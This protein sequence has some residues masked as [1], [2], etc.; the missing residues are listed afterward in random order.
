M[1]YKIIKRL[2]PS[3]DARTFGSMKARTVVVHNTAMDAS[4][5]NEAQ[6][7]HSKKGGVTYHWAVDDKEAIQ[8][9]PHNKSGYHAG[10]GGKKDGGRYGIGVEICYSKSGGARYNKAEENA[11]HLCAQILKEEGLTINNLSKHQ[12]WSGKYCPHRI[13]SHTGW[14]NFKNKVA[15]YMK[16]STPVKSEPLKQETGAMTQDQYILLDKRSVV[17]MEATIAWIKSKVKSPKL[18]CSVDE[19]VKFYYI[20]GER[21]NV[22]PDIALCLSIKETGWWQYGGI[23]LPNQNNF[24]GL[25]AFNNNKQGDAASFKNAQIGAR[26]IVQHLRGYATKEKPTQAI[27]DPRYQALI[28]KKLLGNADTY[29]KLSGKWAW[30]GYNTKK[31]KSY[32]DAY[33]AGETYGQDI[34]RLYEQLKKFAETYKPPAEEE[35]KPAPTPKPIEDKVLIGV[36]ADASADLGAAFRILNHVP[37]TVLI[38]SRTSLKDFKEVIQVGGSKKDGTTILLSGENRYLTDEKVTQWLEKQ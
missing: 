10:D 7:V 14:Q 8:L 35:S 20:E 1:N 15:N 3:S 30:P 18:T 32:N 36:L 19:L 28:D 22:R 16:Q 29:H 24:G 34:T 6:Y 33:R 23:V 38:D 2:L 9:L 37:N 31:F 5:A 4:A 21:E 26:A 12:D 27:V 11:A 17:P 13:L 25:A